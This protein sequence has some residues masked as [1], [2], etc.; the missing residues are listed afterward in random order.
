M[1]IKVLGKGLLSLTLAGL[2]CISHI[3][4]K[5]QPL[6]GLAAYWQLNG[7]YTDNGP[8]N[9][10]VTNSG[11]TPTADFSGV[12]NAAMN[13]VNTGTNAT[14][15]A[16][17]AINGN[18]NF[19]GNADFTFDFLA[20]YASPDKNGGFYDNN[21]NYSGPGIWAWY[22]N[23]FLQLQFNYKNNSIGT[24]NG[25]LQLNTWTHVTCTRASG[26]LSIYINGVLNATGNEGSQNPV[27]AYPAKFGTQWFNAAPYFNYNG[28]NGKMDEF[29]I[30]NRVLTQGEINQL[31]C[32]Y[33]PSAGPVITAAGDT[34]FC[35]GGMVSLT[36]SLVAG[37]QWYKDNVI[38][39]GATSQSLNVF[40]SGIYTAVN[41]QN[42]CASSASNPIRVTVLPKP[43]PGN[44]T[45]LQLLCPGNTINLTTVFNTTGL[46]TLWNTPNIANASTGSYLLVVSD[47]QG[48]K[49]SAVVTII[50]DTAVWT[51]GT[52]SNWYDPANWSSGRV[53]SAGTH[54]IIN[55]I[56][57]NNCVIGIEPGNPKVASVQIR[58]GGVLQAINNSALDVSGSCTS[59]PG[60]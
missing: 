25:A 10:I 55:G 2:L 32:L 18:L 41:A 52:S 38:I 35:E 44:D 16:S 47:N 57:P 54:V 4:L 14:Q 46:N 19:S 22:S 28:L 27:Y 58:N 30:Y 13:F 37:N 45:T 9:I 17:Q 29:R 40:T 1:D 15:F 34:T 50:L 26:I 6:T 24:T 49:D 60:N 5:A 3:D 33:F 12:S 21:M 23:G 56:S 51:G 43:Q 48:C 20:Y 42:A 31:Q 59:L 53:P 36:S 11:S 8:N 7:N 39:S